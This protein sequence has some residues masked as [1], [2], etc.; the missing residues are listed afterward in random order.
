MKRSGMGS[1]PKTPAT[2]GRRGEILEFDRPRALAA[3]ARRA[4]GRT[5]DR[6]LFLALLE[7]LW[8]TDEFEAMM[9]PLQQI[10]KRRYAEAIAVAIALRDSWRRDDIGHS[11]AA[12]G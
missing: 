3:F 6:A 11:I 9:G 12:L 4:R 1:C 10:P 8:V 5:W 2:K 7:E